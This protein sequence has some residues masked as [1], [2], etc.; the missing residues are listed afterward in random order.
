MDCLL[1][2][3]ACTNLLDSLLGISEKIITADFIETSEENNVKN[4]P[5]GWFFVQSEKVELQRSVGCNYSRF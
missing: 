3:F 5:C 4:Q 1:G 2:M